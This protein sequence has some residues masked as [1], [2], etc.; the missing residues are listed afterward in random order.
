MIQPLLEPGW[1]NAILPEIV[2]CVAGI[3]IIL[4]DA[5]A[6]RLRGIVAPLALISLI[7]ATWAESFVQAG[8]FFGGTYQ[9]STITRVFDMTFLLAAILATLFASEY[10][11]RERISGGE[12]YALL[13]WGTVGMM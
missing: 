3:V 12:F 5:S 1:V 10:L 2:L 4:L 8:T 13:L 9:I 11:N 7:A 6:P